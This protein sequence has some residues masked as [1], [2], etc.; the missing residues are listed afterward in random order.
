MQSAEELRRLLEKLDRIERLASSRLDGRAKER[1]LREVERARSAVQKVLGELRIDQYD[2]AVALNKS[3]DSVL[4]TFSRLDPSDRGAVEEAVWRLHVFSNYVA[5]SYYDFS[6]RLTHVRRAYRLYVLA[7]VLAMI[8]TPIF[9]RAG[10]LMLGIYVFALL[11]SIHAFRSRRKLGPLIAAALLPLILFISIIGLR[12]AVY[13]LTT[14]SEIERIIEVAGF[15]MQT[16]Y[17]VVGAI[18]AVSAAALVL[19]V[20]SMYV[21]YRSMDAFV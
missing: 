11:V 20:Y 6:S 12:Y 13:A 10:F 5:A 14:P 17:V 4:R 18:L 16:A 3:A 19:A 8:L 1:A 21:I 15:S 7:A 9:L 2:L